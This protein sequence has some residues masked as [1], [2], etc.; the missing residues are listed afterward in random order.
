[1]GVR[2]GRV[3]EGEELVTSFDLCGLALALVG[4]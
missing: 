2:E 4:K 1:M 3:G